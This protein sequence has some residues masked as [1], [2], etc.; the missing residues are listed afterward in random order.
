MRLGRLHPVSLAVLLLASTACDGDRGHTASGPSEAATRSA[1][2]EPGQARVS[3]HVE[4]M[5]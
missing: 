2:L 3:L 1:P 5:T 4:G